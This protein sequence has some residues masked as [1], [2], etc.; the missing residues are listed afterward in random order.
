LGED[1]HS[2]I[3]RSIPIGKGY[4]HLAILPREAPGRTGIIK[5]KIAIWTAHQLVKYEVAVGFSSITRRHELQGASRSR[6]GFIRLQWF[7]S[8]E[9]VFKPMISKGEPT[10]VEHTGVTENE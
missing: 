7:P 8:C 10:E 4:F 6:G 2:W 1:C 9:E 5:D 3:L